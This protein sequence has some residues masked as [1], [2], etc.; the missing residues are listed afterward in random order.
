MKKKVLPARAKFLKT[1]SFREKNIPIITNAEKG[2]EK[3]SKLNENEVPKRNETIKR[4]FFFEEL[5]SKK[6]ISALA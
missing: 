1:Q 5:I 4:Y 3:G 6:L 2:I